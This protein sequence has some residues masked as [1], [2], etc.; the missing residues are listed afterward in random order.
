MTE[1]SPEKHYS[2][3]IS[4]AL[5]MPSYS[6]YEKEYLKSLKQTFMNRPMYQCPVCGV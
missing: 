1:K 4:N 5:K 2:Q 3:N 6:N